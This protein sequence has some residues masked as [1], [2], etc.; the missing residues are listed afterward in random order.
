M[1]KISILILLLTCFFNVH[2]RSMYFIHSSDDYENLLKQ[3]E[4]VISI[5]LWMT[6][7]ERD[8]FD[9]ARVDLNTF[10]NLTSV[11]IDVHSGHP[12]V[13]SME[14]S[15]AESILLKKIQENKNI[16]ELSLDTPFRHDFSKLGQIQALEISNRCSFTNN[17]YLLFDSVRTLNISYEST[18]EIP[19]D[20]PI[21]HLKNVESINILFRY[22]T[23]FP[24]SSL[25]NLKALRKISISN[26]ERRMIEIP[27]SWKELKELRE[28]Q[29]MGSIS[30]IPEWVCE[31]PVFYEL[32][33]NS[34]IFPSFPD[35]LFDNEFRSLN[36]YLSS[37][38]TIKD[39][40]K[41]NQYYKKKLKNI[42]VD[43]FDY[44]R[45]D[46][47]KGESISIQYLNESDAKKL[48]K[49]E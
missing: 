45:K 25:G 39:R 42:S 14:D 4:K 3:P 12:D 34:D 17:S 48:Y 6:P 35:C 5:N 16:T 13:T 7:Y 31:L 2:S 24:F 41:L 36:L 43:S 30:K 29:I 23:H 38:A 11:N 20:S 19:D 28:L 10:P 8:H 37:Y 40:R 18:H 47:Y 49:E 27:D 32:D 46:W 1:K 15:L 9:F 33:I 21:F 26:D 44:G 22:L